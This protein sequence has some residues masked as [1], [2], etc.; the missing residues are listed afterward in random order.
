M[1]WC[2]R[3]LQYRCS[4]VAVFYL[5]PSHRPLLRGSNVG[6]EPMNSTCD[7]EGCR[8]SRRIEAE[9]KN[10]NRETVAIVQRLWDLWEAAETELE[11][12]ERGVV[13]PG[14]RGTAE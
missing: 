11:A 12:I 2:D 6:K 14:R 1:G 13:E 3:G 7:C 10:W 5:N 4:P 9:K 8:L